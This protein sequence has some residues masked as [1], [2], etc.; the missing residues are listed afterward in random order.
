[1]PRRPT[2]RPADHARN[3]GTRSARVGMAHGLTAAKY[4]VTRGRL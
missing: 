2:A 3:S 1:M 4:G